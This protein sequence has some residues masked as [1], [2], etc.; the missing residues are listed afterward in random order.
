MKLHQSLQS[1]HIQDCM[2]P[3][4]RADLD[5]QFRTTHVRHN[6]SLDSKRFLYI[7]LRYHRS[8]TQYKEFLLL[9]SLLHQSSYKHR[10]RQLGQ[11]ALRGS[12]RI[13]RIVCCA[14]QSDVHYM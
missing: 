9:H 14:F 7:A 12:S 4:F 1:Y 11:V 2:S 5:I 6:Q 10:I 8:N 3:I 13:A